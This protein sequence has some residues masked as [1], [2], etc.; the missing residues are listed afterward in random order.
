M[1]T[2]QGKVLGVA[3]VVGGAL[4]SFI[5]LRTIDGIGTRIVVALIGLGIVGLGSLLHSAAKE[6]EYERDVLD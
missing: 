6:E 4:L 3:L 2:D 1:T 5:A